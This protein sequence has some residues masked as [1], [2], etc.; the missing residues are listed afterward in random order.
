MSEIETANP[1]AYLP[2]FNPSNFV[3][4]NGSLLIIEFPDK[5]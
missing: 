3:F 1:N 2:K 5:P 4:T